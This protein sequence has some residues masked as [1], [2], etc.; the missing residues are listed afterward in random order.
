MTPEQ[1]QGYVQIVSILVSMGAD[2]YGKVGELIHRFSPGVVATEEELNDIERQGI[3]DSQR[4]M[5]ERE[6]MGRG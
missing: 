5:R 4:R 6:E 2:V 3:A 1:I